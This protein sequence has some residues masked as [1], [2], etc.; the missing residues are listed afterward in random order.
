MSQEC[1][2]A[3]RLH[4]ARIV[5]AK[6]TPFWSD[7]R[8]RLETDCLLLAR[9]FPDDIS[10]HCSFSSRDGQCELQGHADPQISATLTIS[11]DAMAIYEERQ[12]KS[13]MVQRSWVPFRVD[14]QDTIFLQFRG[15]SVWSPA[16]FA[17]MLIRSVINANG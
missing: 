12:A 2:I 10:K 14:Q 16:K 4:V 13:T 5:R 3:L 9:I 6:A 11:V 1:D 8:D 17:E 15:S 7:V